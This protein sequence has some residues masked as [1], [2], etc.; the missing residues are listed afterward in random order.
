MYQSQ[1]CVSTLWINLPL[2]LAKENRYIRRMIRGAIEIQKHYNFN[3]E[4]GWKLS[5]TWE[6][7]IKSLKSKSNQVKP[8]QYARKLR[9]RLR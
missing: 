7:L 5:K 3:R 4:A 1:L 6:P 2:V 9:N 8:G